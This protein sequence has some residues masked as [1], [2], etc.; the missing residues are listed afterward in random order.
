MSFP[1]SR[2]NTK[3]Y[4]PYNIHRPSKYPLECREL[5]IPQTIP[6]HNAYTSLPAKMNRKGYHATPMSQNFSEVY[7]DVDRFV[8]D[9]LIRNK[10]LSNEYNTYP[11][12][13]DTSVMWS[14]PGV[15]LCR[16]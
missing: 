13:T 3:V 7:G 1:N 8:Q 14:A 12:Y 5:N 6:F 16:N 15:N 9:S 11:F 10:A 4:N 2:V